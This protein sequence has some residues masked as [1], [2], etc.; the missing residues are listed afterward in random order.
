MFS[1]FRF[2]Y[3]FLSELLFTG[4]PKQEVIFKKNLLYARR[5]GKKPKCLLRALTILAE[6]QS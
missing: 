1:F 4:R 5:L 2:V 3:C 6:D